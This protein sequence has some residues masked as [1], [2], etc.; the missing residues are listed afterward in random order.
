MPELPRY[1]QLMPAST[2]VQSPE[3]PTTSRTVDT[4][5]TWTEQ[6]ELVMP[7]YSPDKRIN[8]KA[9]AEEEIARIQEKAKRLEDQM[10]RH[11]T[12]KENAGIPRPRITDEMAYER[13]AEKPKLAWIL[14]GDVQDA[15][16]IKRPKSSG[17]LV[18]ST[19]EDPPDR[20]STGGTLV[21][22]NNGRAP[23][24]S[25]SSGALDEKFRQTAAERK[26]AAVERK[27]SKRIRF[28]CTFC[29][30]R[31]AGRVEWMRHERS[32]HMPEELWV[33]CPRTGEFPDR[34]PFCAKSDPSPSHLAD[35]NYLSCQQKPLSERTFNQKDLFLQH[36]S[37]EHKISLG[38]KPVRLAELLEAWRHPLPLTQGHQALHCGFCGLTF[39]S[40]RERTEHVAGHFMAGLDMMSWWPSRISHEVAVFRETHR[41]P[42]APHQCN[43]CERT[44]EN[45]ATAQK[46]HPV[47]TMW[48]CSFLPGMQYTI[49]PS[50]PRTDLEAVCCYCNEILVKGNGRVKGAVLKEHVAQHNFRD[51]NQRLYFSGQRF[52]QHLQDAH[53]TNHDGT[54]FAGW[55]LLLKSSKRERT[56]FF[57]P[58]DATSVR[59]AYTDPSPTTTKPQSKKKGNDA[60]PMPRLNFMDFSETPITATIPRKKLRRKPSAQTLPEKPERETRDSTSFFTRAA[61]IDL[62]YGTSISPSPRLD[63]TGVV[64]PKYSLPQH[65]PGFPIASH[66]VDA[67]S[68]CLKFYRRRLDASTRNRLYI[69]DEIDGPLSKN[70]QRLFRKIPASAF[71]G[72][73]LHS[74]LVGATPARLT[75]S[76]DI[77]SL[78]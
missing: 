48:S 4:E 74:S 71:G 37:H 61:T 58:V 36:V 55:T 63:A 1:D 31:F 78:H 6:M 9:K 39:S 68:S 46:L 70:S 17:S 5:K 69:R 29:Q 18:A 49:Y 73:V 47:C 41:N 15:K 8:Y 57:Q 3:R 11:R 51:C 67:V 25:K 12:E 38:Q 21:E 26:S 43:Y 33:C 53:K 35:H 54:L 24:R 52:R 50:G 56:A 34:C 64:A 22:S 7:G 45:L 66:P 60:P 23:R 40:Y 19:M 32:T 44:Y 16:S 30:K 77:Y 42:D 75:N 10:R 76:V 27:P 2:G 14:G 72:L 65:K 62:A 13:M 28:Y 59:R 20:P